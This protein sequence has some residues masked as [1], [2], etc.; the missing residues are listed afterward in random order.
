LALCVCLSTAV[1]IEKMT[2]YS[3]DPLVIL[4]LERSDGVIGIGQLGRSQMDSTG[5]LNDNDLVVDAFMRHVAP[6]A[7]GADISTPTAVVNLTQHIV[8]NNYKNTGQILSR[9]LAGLDTAAWD[10]I[11]KAENRSVCDAVA[12]RMNP[13][14]ACRTEVDLYC[15]NITRYL[16]ADAIVGLVSQLHTDYRINKFKYKIGLTMGQNGDVSV[17]KTEDEIPYIRAELAKKFGVGT[18]ALIV[19]ANGGYTDPAHARH[20]AALLGDNGYEWFEEP[21]PF[22]DYAGTK[23]MKDLGLLKIAAGE[24]EYRIDMF[25][26]M[27]AEKTV[28]IVQPDFGYAGGF[29]NVLHVADVAAANGIVVDPHSPDK[30]MT[31][32]FS[33]HLLGAISNAGPALEYGCVDPTDISKTVFKSPIAI[34]RNGTVEIP[35]GLGWGVEILDS[36][37]NQAVAQTYPAAA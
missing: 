23:A 18:I 19:D 25:E 24:N 3:N 6:A 5:I 15:T 20:I 35:T 16:S 34:T 31:E 4:Y 32:F 36:W 33:L 11:A 37:L 26:R 21:V 30:S 10:A 27:L 1:T 13:P 9:A 14:R 22:W 7:L 8:Y 28:D 12:L 2:V 17:N 29:S